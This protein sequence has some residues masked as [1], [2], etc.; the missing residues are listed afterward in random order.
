MKNQELYRI[1]KGQVSTNTIKIPFFFGIVYSDNGFI[2][3]ELYV[4]E[5]YDLK[6]L[7]KSTSR[8]YLNYEYNLTCLTEENNVLKIDNLRF[9]QN[10]PHLS[11]IKMVC[12]GKMEHIKKKKKGFEKSDFKPLI[13]YLILEGLKIEFS[14]FTEKIRA[15]GGEK[16]E[17]FDNFERD[18]T[19]TNLVHK[20]CPYSQTYYK[21]SEKENDIIVEFTDENSNKL[22][23]DKY[24]ELKDYYISALSFINGA[25][26]RV[27]KECYGSY[28]SIGKIDAEKTVTYS[29]KRIDNRRY[30]RY[31]PINDP[32][33]RAERVLSKFFMCN[34]DQ[35]INWCD[36]VDLKSIIYYLNNSEQT[37][38]IEEKV[39]IQIIAFERLT[40]M[41]VEYLGEKEEFLPNKIDY[42]PIKDELNKIIEQNKDKFGNAYDTIKSKIGNLN[43]IKR[44]ST[45]DKLY[46]IINDFD[47]PI[48]PKIN[49]LID[50]VRHKT[51][52][53]GD[54]GEGQ[55]GLTT[56]YL[57]DELIREII[58]RM[59]D[60]KGKRISTILLN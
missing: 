35:Y 34:F 54:I 8:E 31:I 30:N 39:F 9:S 20:Q 55:D 28:F 7:M 52:H 40:T 1:K 41:Y 37:N 45:T 6:D 36:K 49:K 42:K 29:F 3:L 48:T 33:H 47:I 17:D 10:T 46:R 43:Q 12:Y 32:F 11:R 23:Y 5:E 38:S 13:K 44:H 15:R 53:R 58:L 19:T 22:T 24:L 2:R 25:E 56:F 50:V 26:V 51:V 27:K 57:L 60:Y 4:N 18:H 59:V 21:L 14:D 16:M